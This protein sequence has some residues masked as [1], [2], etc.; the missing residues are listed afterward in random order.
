MADF[1]SF[2]FLIISGILIVLFPFKRIKLSYTVLSCLNGLFLGLT[3]VASWMPNYAKLL[4][5]IGMIGSGL[6]KC[7]LMF[8]Y[9]LVSEYFDPS[10]EAHILNV[11]YALLVV[12][13]GLSFFLNSI[14]LDEWRLSWQT[15]F[16]IWIGLMCANLILQQMA[17]GEVYTEQEEDS[18]TVIEKLKEIKEFLASFLKKPTHALLALDYTLEASIVYNNA[19]WVTYFFHKLDFGSISPLIAMGF[20]IM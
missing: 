10:A 11:W 8:P 18:R 9:I 4:I 19:L 17:V 14:M 16:A 7:V 3:I 1:L 12:G 13:E 20:L 15:V 2:F 5:V 6:A